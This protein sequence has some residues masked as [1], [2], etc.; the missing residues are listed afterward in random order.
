MFNVLFL[1]L[2][3]FSWANGENIQNMSGAQTNTESILK[4]CTVTANIEEDANLVTS[5]S[6][7]GHATRTATDILAKITPA[8]VD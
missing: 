1:S 4:E 3:V 2:L 5:T 6:I 7:A 8:T